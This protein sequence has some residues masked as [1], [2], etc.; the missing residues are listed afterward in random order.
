MSWTLD[1]HQSG[2]NGLCDTGVPPVIDKDRGRDAHV[3][4]VAAYWAE[5]FGGS[6]GGG[7]TSNTPGPRLMLPV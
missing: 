4:D 6:L 7:N 5:S 1:Y 2:H 3:R